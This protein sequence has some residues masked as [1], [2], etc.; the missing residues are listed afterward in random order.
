MPRE[1]GW[2]DG[3]HAAAPIPGDPLGFRLSGPQRLLTYE[4][5]SH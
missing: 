2:G 3:G 1:W 4:C 5:P